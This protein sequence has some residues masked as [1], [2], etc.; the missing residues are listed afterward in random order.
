MK[1]PFRIFPAKG[2]YYH[3]AAA[4]YTDFKFDKV[5]G[6]DFIL[7][8]ISTQPINTVR[9]DEVMLSEYSAAEITV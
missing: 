9:F 6:L 3:D 4:L 1:F 7:E 8:D 2:K 5:T